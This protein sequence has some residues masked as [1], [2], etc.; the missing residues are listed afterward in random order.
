M[1]AFMMC[2]QFSRTVAPETGK[3]PALIAF[4]QHYNWR[5]IAI[6]SSTE[7]IWFEARL[8]L[9]KCFEAAGIQ[10]LM[11]AA[12]EPGDVKDA[13]LLTIRQSGYRVMLVLS[14]D[15]DAYSL[16]SLARRDGMTTG[17]AWL[18][19][20]EMTSMVPMAGWLWF[21]PF[22]P[23]DMQTFAKEVSDYTK[24]HFNISVDPDSVNLA[25]SA[26][27]YDAIMLYAHAATA[28]MSKGGD[29]HDGEAVTA[30]VRNTSFTGVGG[31]AVTLNSEGDRIESYEVMNYVLEEGD[32][33]RSVAVG[34]WDSVQSQYNAYEQPVLWPG[35][36]TTVPGDFF[37]SEDASSLCFREVAASLTSR[38][39]TSGTAW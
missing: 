22:L 16:A 17:W 23:S 10:A 34:I 35:G 3:S 18:V 14:Y 11:P 9:A 32:V 25:F 20:A 13:M 6:L 36:M 28:V 1:D 38:E 37:L 31:T 15:D 39:L 8:G 24:S 29:L 5:R 30:A 19:P 7:S 26:A 33:I 2:L 27:L 4:M 21:R 12:F